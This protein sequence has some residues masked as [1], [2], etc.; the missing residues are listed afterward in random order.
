MEYRIKT[1]ILTIV[2]TVLCTTIMG[3]SSSMQ[4]YLAEA[5]QIPNSDYRSGQ[6]KINGE[7]VSSFDADDFFSSYGTILEKHSVSSIED[8]QSEREV[9]ELFDIRGF[10]QYPILSYYTVEGTYTGETEITRTGEDKHPIYETSYVCENGEIWTITF[11][12][13]VFTALP[14]DYNFSSTSDSITIVAE[15]KEMLSYDSSTNS[16]YRTIPNDDQMHVIVVERINALSLE[17]LS[18]KGIKDQ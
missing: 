15:S 18:S 7:S 5:D 16:Y 3:C 1:V 12:N 10:N 2:F 17:E 6:N 14:E 9:Y 11:M 8:L 13:G 4:Q